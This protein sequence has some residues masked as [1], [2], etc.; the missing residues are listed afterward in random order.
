MSRERERERERGMFESV[1]TVAFQ[2]AFHVEL[3]QNDIFFIF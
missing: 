1:V 2:S 3:H